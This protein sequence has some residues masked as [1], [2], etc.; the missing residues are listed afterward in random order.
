[1]T[2]NE[3]RTFIKEK[4]KSQGF[5]SQKSYLYKTI[6][7]DYLIGFH[8]YPSTYC[9]GYSFVCGIIYLPDPF[10]IPLRGIY[11]LEW[12]FRFPVH[13]GGE[14]D[15]KKY[16]DGARFTT[17]FQYENYSTEDL[18]VYFSMN[19]EHFITPLFDKEYG[20]QLLREDWHIMNRF[21]PQTIDKLCKRASLNT[22]IV[23]EYLGKNM[24]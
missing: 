15:L 16:Q 6:D 11:D 12:S 24:L 4:F 3:L 7:D 20:L 9:K 14:L 2:K 19:Y 18:E 21:A 23:L 17:V 13:P 8:L 5:S 1:M 10:K 22:Q